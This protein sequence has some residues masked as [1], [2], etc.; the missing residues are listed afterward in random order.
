MDIV[1]DAAAAPVGSPAPPVARAPAGPPSLSP[2]GSPLHLL[3]RPVTPE[4]FLLDATAPVEQHFALSAELPEGH[5][6]F[7]DG[8]GTFHDL[9][10]AAESLRQATHFVAHQYFRVPAERPAV[11]VSSGMD[12]ADLTPWRRTGRPAHMTLDITL[13]PVDVVNGIPRGLDCR[14]AVAIDGTPCGGGTA[15]LLF[16]MPRVYRAHRELGRRE[17]LQGN[18]SAE[19]SGSA[20]A[21]AGTTGR[22]AVGPDRVARDDPG[23]VLV[24]PPLRAIDG[25]FVL[26][27][28]AAPGHE[29]FDGGA[30]GHIPGPVFLEAS[31]QAALIVAA[32]LHGFSP[33]HAVLTHW[34]ASFRGFGETDLPLTCTITARD[35]LRDTA[36]RP[37]V[38]TRIA[39]SQGSRVLA[40]ATATLLQDC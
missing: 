23:N 22:P 13:T 38:R 17:S 30:E 9:L 36:G 4:G 18:V 7:N 28:A 29:L 35:P 3:H 27:V 40:T 37:T 8:P 31:R 25:E 21:P 26:P 1:F 6:V 5:G 14:G 16:L 33:A 20:P 32:E 19:A 12:I 10:F 11:F 39:F 2:A 15:R 24:G 34:W